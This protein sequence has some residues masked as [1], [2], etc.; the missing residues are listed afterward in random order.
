M[1]GKLASLVLCIASPFAASQADAA[2]QGS[3]DA[4]SA[5]TVTISVSIAPRAQ[6]S[7]PEEIDLGRTG[8]TAAATAQDLCLSSNLATH[9]FVVSAIGSGKGGALELSNGQR[10]AGYTLDLEHRGE[11]LSGAHGATSLKL[12]A[13]RSRGEC[14]AGRGSADLAVALD[15]AQLPEGLGRAPYSG[16]LTLIVSPE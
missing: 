7:A 4:V 8:K 2:R 1:N 10:S 9:A 6:L 13:G 12:Q 15:P 16:T 3:L 11:R 14:E 5:G